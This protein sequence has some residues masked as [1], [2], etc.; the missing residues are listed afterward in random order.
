MIKSIFFVFTV[1]MLLF[2]CKKDDTIA[3]KAPAYKIKTYSESVTSGSYQISY[4]FNVNYDSQDRIVSL[5]STAGAG[6]RFE[7]HYEPGKVTMEIF[8][9]NA[10]AIHE[11][12]Y[13]NKNNFPDS[14]YQYNDTQDYSTERYIYNSG[15]QLTTRYDYDFYP[16]YGS[17]LYNTVNYVWDSNGNIV[18]EIDQNGTT[19]YEY[20]LT[21][22]SVVKA[23]VDFM[24]ASKNLV[25]KTSF[26]DGGSTIVFNHAYTFDAENRVSTETITSNT[27]ETAVRS[28]TYY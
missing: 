20:D 25:T 1:A 28:Y 12:F 26:S 4:T 8:G 10:L 16:G 19:S 21:H 17:S 2:S 13:L 11:E 15:K 14:T 24:P 6:D 18:K 23:L 9:S 3:D 7:W 22:P 27:G 5:V